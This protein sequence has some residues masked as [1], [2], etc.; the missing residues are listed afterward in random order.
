LEFAV[1]IQSHFCSH[2]NL[3]LLNDEKFPSDFEY[4]WSFL[5]SPYPKLNTDTDFLTSLSEIYLLQGKSRDVQ[6]TFSQAKRIYVYRDKLLLETSTAKDLPEIL[7]FG[8][9]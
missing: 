4:N 5:R 1:I 2:K 8:L 7:A 3:I 9:V 6:Y